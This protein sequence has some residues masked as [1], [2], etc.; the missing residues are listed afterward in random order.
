MTLTEQ[1]RNCQDL[2]ARAY[3]AG[4]KD[5]I[6]RFSEH[7][8]TLIQ[9]IANTGIRRVCPEN[10]VIDWFL[11]TFVR[12]TAVRRTLFR[13]HSVLPSIGWTSV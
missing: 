5:A 12:Q 3:P 10:G 7:R 4:D 13:R 9:Q 11:T 1:L 2:L 6:R 8:L